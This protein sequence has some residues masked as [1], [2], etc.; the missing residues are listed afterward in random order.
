MKIGVN[1][2]PLAPSALVQGAQAAERLG[3]DSVWLG[4][5]VVT[6][7][8]KYDEYQ[9][10]SETFDADGKFLEPFVALG[11]LATVTTTI[12]LGTGVVLLPLRDPFLTA[13]SIVTVDVLSGGRLDLGVGSGWLIE[14][15]EIMGKDFHARG[16]YMDEFLEV[17]DLLYTQDRSEFQG[18]YYKFPTVGFQPKPVQPG[19]PR[20]LVGGFAPAALARAARYDGWYGYIDTAEDVTRFVGLLREERAKL[21]K[22]DEPFEI[23][24]VH[25]GA[26]TREQAESYAAAGLDR[27]VVT[28]WQTGNGPALVGAAESLDELEQYAADVGVEA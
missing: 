12:R 17:L 5:H 4:E 7:A 20:T 21:G 22:A 16:G 8:R 2:S 26:P 6:P 1:V 18:R 24:A 28:P 13:R 9:G 10:S 3:F 11:A 27:L 23:A 19:R 15:F 14:E 25:L